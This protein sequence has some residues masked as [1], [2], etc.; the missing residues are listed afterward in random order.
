M[1]SAFQ[2]DPNSDQTYD[3]DSSQ[4]IYGPAAN[5]NKAPGKSFTMN[6][7]LQ[8]LGIHVTDILSGIIWGGQSTS[9]YINITSGTF[10][11]SKDS[12]GI[13]GIG[14]LNVILNIDENGVF[15]IDEVQIESYDPD[16]PDA[17][18]TMMCNGNFHSNVTALPVAIYNF[19]LFIMGTGQFY[20]GAAGIAIGK[21]SVYVKS[22]PSSGPAFALDAPQMELYSQIAVYESPAL[23]RA[24]ELL[25][26]SNSSKGVGVIDA[27]L[28]SRIQIQAD[29]IRFD[30]DDNYSPF[31]L[32]GNSPGST[33][34]IRFDPYSPSHLPFD[35]LQP[36]NPPYPQGMFNILTGGNPPGSEYVIIYDSN[37][38]S[39]AATAVLANK[40]IAVDGQP[41]D[42]TDSRVYCRYENDGYIH[43]RLNV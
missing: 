12:E 23:F 38:G 17:S 8:T 36:Q 10:K 28:N 1:A 35:F 34:S 7:P 20:L 21:S 18:S 11:I 15:I 30:Y 42:Q 3:A 40:L 39:A 4:D 31:I 27:Q 41:V 29:L 14:L 2:W 6:A 5:F 33:A 24:E 43:I 25:I 37:N 9:C 13:A 16:L 22:N 19:S 26:G 32:R